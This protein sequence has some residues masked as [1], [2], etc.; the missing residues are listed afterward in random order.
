MKSAVHDMKVMSLRSKRVNVNS[1][2]C[3]IS[4]QRCILSHPVHMT[5]INLRRN[6]GNQE[7]VLW[8]SVAVSRLL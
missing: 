3:I 7:E 8:R 1:F 6:Y 5:A 4:R 2:I